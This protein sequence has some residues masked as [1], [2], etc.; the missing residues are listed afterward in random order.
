MPDQRAVEDG[1]A[2]REQMAEPVGPGDVIGDSAEAGN[3]RRSVL[4]VAV[5]DHGS[6]LKD[7]GLVEAR[8]SATS[9]IHYVGGDPTAH[10]VGLPAFAAVRRGFQARSSVAGPVNHNDRRHLQLLA[11]RYLELHIHLADG[12]LAGG[13]GLI[14]SIGGGRGG[15]VGDLRHAADEEAALVF[16]DQRLGQEFFHLRRFPRG[17]APR[18]GE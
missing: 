18:Q 2:R 11:R 12:D 1:R 9:L 14:G 13:V 4:D 3:L 15:I 10:E 6:G 5:P 16:D 17:G 8:A 7:D